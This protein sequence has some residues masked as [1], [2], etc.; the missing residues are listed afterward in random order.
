MSMVQPDA[1]L[2]PRPEHFGLTEELVAAAPAAVSDRRRGQWMLGIYAVVALAVLALLLA[3][4]GSVAASLL[5]TVLVVAAASVL[6]LPVIAAVVCG[7]ERCEQLWLCR[8]HAQLRA[9]D[10]YR[11]ALAAYDDTRRRQGA[12]QAR[13]GE[14]FWRSLDRPALVEEVARLY[15]GLG[16]TVE[17]VADNRDA[18]VDIVVRSGRESIVI[19]CHAGCTAQGRALGREL[20]AARRDLGADRAVLVVPAGSG[21]DLAGY[22]E[23]HSGSVLDAVGLDR[24]RSAGV[25]ECSADALP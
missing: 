11:Q 7:V 23:E 9:V 20:A 16:Q 4:S 8:H 6:L 24:L 14:A 5:L 13:T 21:D 17:I 19:R 3:T 25:P 12:E 10:A 15:R 1:P 18:G 2:R 22:L